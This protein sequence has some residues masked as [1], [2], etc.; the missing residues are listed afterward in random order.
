[1]GAAEVQRMRERLDSVQNSNDSL[2]AARYGP[3]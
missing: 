3:A 2:V 1:M